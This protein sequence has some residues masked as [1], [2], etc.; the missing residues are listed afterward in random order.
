M[1]LV[2]GIDIKLQK[3]SGNTTSGQ[4]PWKK[5]STSIQ[6]LAIISA[7]GRAIKLIKK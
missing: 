5:T 4:K 7:M 3:M 2:T 6:C 1:I